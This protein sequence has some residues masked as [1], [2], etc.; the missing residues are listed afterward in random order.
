MTSLLQKINELDIRIDN[1]ST[2]GGGGAT[3]IADVEIYNL[4]LMP[5]KVLLTI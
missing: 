2:S 5:N 1:I 3:T 4:H